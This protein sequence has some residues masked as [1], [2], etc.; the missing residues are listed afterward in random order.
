MQQECCE[1]VR[2]R[3]I[4]LYK[5]DQHLFACVWHLCFWWVLSVELNRIIVASWLHCCGFF[6][7]WPS[8]RWLPESPSTSHHSNFFV[9]FNSMLY[10]ALDT[11]QLIYE[12]KNTVQKVNSLLIQYYRSHWTR[13]SEFM[14][15]RIQCKKVQYNTMQSEGEVSSKESGILV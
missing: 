6:F 8:D 3:R 9:F 4:A 12:P 7:L 14:K 2:E 5:S 11:D 10:I 13:I 15:Q 1:S